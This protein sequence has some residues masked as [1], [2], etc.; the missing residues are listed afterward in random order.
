MPGRIFVVVTTFLGAAILATASLAAAG[1]DEAAPGTETEDFAAT[2]AAVGA[3]QASGRVVCADIAALDQTLVY[4]RFGSFNPFGM[5]FALNRD[6][7]PLPPLAAADGLVDLS[8][9]EPLTAAQCGAL[10]G[11]ETRA[12]GV[13]LSAGN[14]RLRDCKRPRPMT[15]RTNVGDTLVVH[16]R[17]LLAPTQSPDFSK[18]ICKNTS[19]TADNGREE[20][21]SDL[22]RGEAALLDHDEVDCG[23]PTGDHAEAAAEPIHA[24]DW[25]NTRLVN[26]VAQGL[27]PLPM[28]GENAPHPACFGT[29]AV[30]PDADFH[31]RYRIEQEGTYFFASL[32][33]PAG[34]EGN[35]GSLVHGLFGA[36]MA[37]RPGSRW[38]RSQV[39]QGALNRVWPATGTVPEHTRA[40]SP[41]Y[42]GM[43]DNGTP[44]L[45]MARSLP[46]AQP[47]R[48]ADAPQVDLLELV[49]S[50][51]NAIIWCDKTM[52][53][54]ACGPQ[55]REQA[56]G[57]I[58]T[59][60]E[61]GAFRE[62][63]VFFHDE[64]KTFY[65]RNFRELGQLG[66]LA[67][68]KDGFAINY[69]ASGM[70]SL[71][72]AN[73]K[74]IGPADDCMECL[75]EEFFLTSWANG[76]PAL[77]E[78]YPDD[79]SNVHHSYL[80]DPVVFRNFHAGPKETHVFHLHAH[81]WF[82]GNDPNRGSYLDSQTVAPQQGFTYNI[83]HG[84]QRGPDGKG[85]GGWWDSQGS[86]NR[87]RTVGDSIFHCHLYPH[88]AQGMWALWRVHDVLEDGTRLLPDGQSHAGLSTE[89]TPAT[90]RPDRR[91]GSIDRLTGLW[92]DEQQGTPIPALVPLPGEPLPLAPTYATPADLTADG[93]A[94]K[95]EATTPMPGYP[96][97]IAAEPGHRP[98]QAPLDIARNLGAPAANSAVSDTRDA[99]AVSGTYRAAGEWLDGGLNRHV[100][101]T[102]SKREFGIELPEA[103]RDS[104]EF[105][106][107]SDDKQVMLMRQ[108]IAKAFALG[109]LSGHLI[110]SEI[111]RLNPYGERLER[112]AMGYHHNGK[113]YRPDA[114]AGDLRLQQADGTEVAGFAK[115]GYATTLAG[116][117]TSAPASEPAREAVFY[118]NGAAPRPGAPFADP[119]G[120]WQDD[121]AATP[122]PDPLT[123]W[124]E[125]PLIRDD[126]VAGFRR[127]EA[128]AVQL[129]M[130]VNRAGWHDPQARINVLSF[131]S[132]RFKTGPGLISP[133]IS[134][135]EEPFF[136]RAL[137]GECIEFRHTNELPKELELDDFQVRTP[138]DTIGQHIHLVKFDV[139]ASD[140]SGNGWNYEDGTFAP[141][142]I[143]TRICTSDRPDAR[144][145]TSAYKEH[146]I[147]REKRSA[148]PEWFQTTTQRWFADPILSLDENGKAIDRTMRTVFT[149]DHF[150]P[151]SIQQHGFYAA[152]VIEPPAQYDGATVRPLICD[153]RKRGAGCV[154]P[155]PKADAPTMVAWGS[156]LWQGTRKLIRNGLSDAYHPDYREF[157]LSIADFALLYDPRD[158]E[159]K[160][161]FRRAMRDPTGVAARRIGT[162]EGMA[163]IYCEAR[164]RLSPFNM[165]DTCGTGF[166]RE[167]GRGSFFYPLPPPAWLAGGA[168]RDDRHRAHYH[169]DLMGLGADGKNEVDDLLEHLISYRERAAGAGNRG[170]MAR[171]VA[172]PERPESISVDHHDPY[173]VNYR[174]APIPLRIAD[175]DGDAVM[176]GDCAPWAMNPPGMRGNSDAVRALASG[177]TGTCSRSHQIAGAWGDMAGALHSGLHGDPETPLLEGYQGERL[178]MRMIQGA[179]EVQHTFTLTGQPFKRN[180]DQAFPQGMLP[181][182][183]A[184]TPS[185][186]NLCEARAAISGAHPGKYREWRDTAPANR[187]DW[188]PEDHAHWQA[189]E[190]ALAQCDNIEGFMFAQEIGISEHFEM[191]GSLRA[192][193]GASPEGRDGGTVA[194]IAPEEGPTDVPRHSSDYLYH[195]GSIDALWNGAWGL[196]RIY[197]APSA[198]DPATIAAL[199]PGRDPADIGAPKPI[200]DRL[201]PV[202]LAGSES[203]ATSESANP[204]PALVGGSGLACPLPKDAGAPQRIVQALLVAIET[205]RV[206]DKQGTAYAPG[207]HDPDGLMLALM[208][209]GAQGLP[210]IADT[211][212]L[213]ALEADA[214]IAAIRNVYGS[215]PEPF[216]LRVRAGDCLQLRVLNL[217]GDKDGAMRDVL[218][219]AILPKIVPLN[220]D[221]IPH[222]NEASGLIELERL[223][224]V[225]APSGLRPSAGLAISF[226]LPGLDMIRDVPAGYGYNRKAIAGGHGGVE[227]GPLL[228]SYAGRVR[229]DL[230]GDAREQAATL[231][232]I[233]TGRLRA[234]LAAAPGQ[235]FAALRNTAQQAESAAPVQVRVSVMPMSDAAP[236]TG[237]ARILGHEFALN[238]IAGTA[239][240]RLQA[241]PAALAPVI[242]QLCGTGDCPAAATL[243]GDLQALAGL[244]LAQALDEQTHWI[245]YAFGAVPVKSTGDVISQGPH[246]LF[247][248]IDVVPLGWEAMTSGGLDCAAPA[249]GYE[250]CRAA[251]VPGTGAGQPMR[252]AVTPADA[253]API[254]LREFVLFYQDGL[255]HWDAASPMTSVW[256]DTGRAATDADLGAVRAVPDCAV[257]DDSYDRGEAA[258]S[259][260]SPAL[261]RVLR[262]LIPDASV[263][264][265]SDLNTWAFP[266]DYTVSDSGQPQLA[267]CEGEQ[268]VI[269]VVHPGGRARQRSF[270]MNG[271]SYDELF[272][273]FGFP[274]SALLAPGKAITA[275]LRPEARP[276]TTVW[277]DGPTHLR[278]AG[279]WGLIKVAERGDPQC[280]APEKQP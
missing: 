75:Y 113:L 170:S 52:P 27:A 46:G 180:I 111:T 214:V 209:P 101:T 117:P 74:G 92:H 123:P 260:H 91:A 51:L 110:K 125:T 187:I 98:P 219:D 241:E 181:L 206:F 267:A 33:A 121:P 135:S 184:A 93:M 183:T 34:G 80:N 28:P 258:V 148:H 244:A 84:G 158:R 57:N 85:K 239:S 147:W 231:A 144:C 45:N 261:Y 278:A 139:T 65:T 112:A 49:H 138:T 157:A 230:D 26:F 32:A 211:G 160:R 31:C 8:L 250:F 4:N 243:A 132:D 103:V 217:L 212:A 107:L 197:D 233:A 68:V 23:P 37:E 277:H 16:V 54:A 200:R 205:R 18:N 50:D 151:S 234:M 253:S 104:N 203:T 237:I 159:D 134:D 190:D 272:P 252:Y 274:R 11:T 271:Y 162:L 220:A 133:L 120:R 265:A 108:V 70:G 1:K 232:S 71:L 39:T 90:L 59:E 6:I 62:F 254:S 226:G 222:L 97:Y 255:N 78:W 178:V 155:L 192:D 25:P 168:N 13:A 225:S 185:L 213:G 55:T 41:D 83:Y 153:D 127:Y 122:G 229:I 95:P 40:A 114:G 115:G 17:N 273:G 172:A 9:T 2:C 72:L 240:A 169:G 276:G 188:T 100:I 86:G 96:F 242:T 149:H 48:A 259:Q 5:I 256:A 128:S 154:R 67:G 207:V 189:Y 10:L 174:G 176:S 124:L 105:E 175:K 19:P 69:G 60:P 63:S 109:D 156:D 247:G 236:G 177:P 224:D 56:P 64:L 201:L 215:Q 208:Q 163:K 248:A 35:G 130:I 99:G 216:V 143:A 12:A 246:G 227:A 204:L 238:I 116:T 270:A 199:N 61:Y 53:G 257:C 102:G 194:M 58:T 275:W 167:P 87:N 141:D 269:R 165:R 249:D 66:Q 29:G 202:S 73:R 262:K 146:R 171:P 179:Q 77:L 221:P 119:C 42:E 38:Y 161:S 47:D 145:Q 88:F 24:P 164:Y 22:A 15:L 251:H 94:L 263:G 89:F 126:R 223:P 191:Q 137:S 195:F 280:A 140:G 20:A 245:P 136:F 131:D 44:I 129:D 7:A 118:V 182:A 266:P 36:I 3:E 79:P 264:A 21:T 142:E 218:G 193:V 166:E 14:V 196:M 43:D 173:L 30:A 106:A 198:P 76:D 152:L 235:H 228:T 186:Q 81:Q 150:G 210:D 82:A 268:I 279:T